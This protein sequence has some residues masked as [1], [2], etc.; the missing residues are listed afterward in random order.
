MV[1]C[2]PD[3]SKSDDSD[4]YYTIP[5]FQTL[6]HEQDQTKVDYNALLGKC[7]LRFNSSPIIYDKKRRPSEFPTYESQRNKKVLEDATG[8]KIKVRCSLGADSDDHRRMSWDRS[9]LSIRCAADV[10]HVSAASAGVSDL[11]DDFSDPFPIE[12]WHVHDGNKQMQ[13]VCRA[14]DD[15]CGPS[16][17][18]RARQHKM[19]VP[20]DAWEMAHTYENKENHPAR[21]KLPNWENDFAIYVEDIMLGIDRRTTCMIKNIPNKYSLK[22]LIDLLNEDHAG[23]YNFVYLR[24]DFKN[25]CNV[26]YAFVNFASCMSIVSFYEKVHGKSWKRFT[27]NKICELTYASIQGFEKLV[28]KFRN[29]SIMQEKDSFRPKMFYTKGPKIGTERKLL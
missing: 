1:I 10:R 11:D 22:M 6:M 17:L 21:Q 16:A 2:V 28:N 27:S 26:G 4:V 15:A 5:L 29:S 8:A 25:R 23:T 20:K 3:K 24:M 7:E 14:R 13:V 18:A 9:C 19:R 12:K